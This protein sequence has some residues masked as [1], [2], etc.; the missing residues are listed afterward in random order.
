MWVG[1]WMCMISKKEITDVDDN[2]E[3][4][5][6]IYKT[7]NFFSYFF[8]NRKKE[9]IN[10]KNVDDVD[11]DDKYKFSQNQNVNGS[12]ICML[13]D[14]CVCVCVCFECKYTGQRI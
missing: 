4:E 3:L 10:M 7:N 6:N 5:F 12:F 9:V 14:V 8:S 1:G 2:D 13:A 11:D